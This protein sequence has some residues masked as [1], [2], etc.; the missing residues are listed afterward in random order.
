MQ[1][2]NQFLA[3]HG[4][5]FSRKNGDP[6]YVGEVEGDHYS[7]G[8]QTCKKGKSITN[9]VRKDKDQP[10]GDFFL[11]DES[12]YG[13][14]NLGDLVIDYETPVTEA[15]AVIMDIDWDEEWEI[16]AYNE[17][18]EPID[19]ITLSGQGYK[20]D[21]RP[22]LWKFENL[23]EGETIKQIVLEGADNAGFGLGFDNFSPSKACDTVTL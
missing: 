12:G 15:S 6:L 22:M 5:S 16:T 23:P 21:G 8:C 10:I 13:N 20:Y 17:K 7:W 14:G 9:G 19:T 1:I 18:G 11:T 4:V 3:S 2:T